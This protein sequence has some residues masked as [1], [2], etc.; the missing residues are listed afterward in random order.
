[1]ESVVHSS[2]HQNCHHQIIYANINLKLCH[3]ALHL[4]NVKYGTSNVRRLIKF[5]EQ[6]NS[7]LRK[8]YLE[9]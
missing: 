3:T 2:F 8:N 7:F 5:N 6:L 4:M 1:M 9:V